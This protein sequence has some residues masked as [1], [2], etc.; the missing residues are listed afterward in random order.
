MDPEHM[1]LTT[2]DEWVDGDFDDFPFIQSVLWD[3]IKYDELEEIVI[4]K[5]ESNVNT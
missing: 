2:P 3:S 1:L 4:I 5:E